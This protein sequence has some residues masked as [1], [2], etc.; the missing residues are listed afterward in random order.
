M[1]SNEVTLF[2]SGIGHFRRVYT[3]KDQQTISIPFAKDHIGDVAASLMLFGKAKLVSPPTFTPSNAN[4]TALKID[5]SNTLRSLLTGLSGAKLRV[6]IPTNWVEGVLL[7][8]TPVNR[9]G[10]QGV[11]ENKDLVTMLTAEGI[12][13]Y[14]TDMI[15]GFDFIDPVVKAEIEKAMKVNFNRIKPDSLF[16]DLTLSSASDKEEEVTIQ[17]T[18]PVAAWKMRYAIRDMGGKFSFEGAAVIDNNTDEDWNDF[19]IEVVTGNPISFATDI[20]QVVIP[21]RKMVHL[22]EA[23]A[24]GNVEAA[25]VLESVARGVGRKG[26]RGSS[27]MGYSNAMSRGGPVMMA[28]CAAPEMLEYDDGDGPD[29]MAEAADVETK[30]VGDFCVFTHKEPIT[31]QAKKSAVVPMFSVALERAQT[32]LFY[33]QEKHPRRP[34]RAVKFTNTTDLSLGKGKTIIYKDGVFQG[35]C[36]LEATKPND[37]RMLPHCLENGVRIS[38]EQKSAQQRQSSIKISKGVAI[39][40][41]VSTAVTEYTV[42]NRKDEPFQ[43]T[44]EHANQLHGND[45]VVVCTGV[46]VDKMDRIPNGSQINF[47]LKAGEKFVVTM[48]ETLV[49]AN[50]V[51]LNDY[52]WVQVAIIRTDNPLAKDEKILACA[53]IQ[54]KIDDTDQEESEH[55]DAVGELAERMGRLRENIKASANASG[56][57][58]TTVAG[59]VTD[60][61]TAEKAIRD[62]QDNKIPALREQRKTLQKEL[63]VALKKLSVE[64]KETP[65]KAK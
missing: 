2:S 33:K 3:V 9:I 46:V 57:C 7:G 60:L 52:S 24:L 45:L 62:L 35:E 20:A 51:T 48:T 58:T 38:A 64:W 41:L 47:S 16:L 18:I 39:Q 19:I 8:V 30:E 49:R 63:R 65:K 44:I 27:A 54:E 53:A 23:N 28:A 42:E 32:V 11:M 12:Q 40:E 61:N 10:F 31:I 6:K 59:W 56:G 25:E 21:E 5:P 55:R 17:Y 4:L 50:Q 43:V 26:I 34:F 1:R 37:N 36:V 22:V 29:M 14:S 15:Q 13:Q